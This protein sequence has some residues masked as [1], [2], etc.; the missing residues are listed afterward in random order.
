MLDH[1]SA[2]R[3]GWSYVMRVRLTGLWRHPDFM[4]LWGGATISL[5]GS[6]ITFIALTL[7]AAVSL[8]AT[9]F[10]IG[11]LAA[12]QGAPSLLVGLVAGIWVDRMRRRPI[13]IVTDLGRAVLLASIPIATLVGF[14]RI[15]QLYV[16]MFGVGSL[17]IF[18]AIASNAFLV[19]VVHR[20]QLMEAN[21]KLEVSQSVAL[22]AGPGIG[23][24]LIL[25]LSAPVAI[26]ADVLS[27]LLSALCFIL[28]NVVE[29]VPDV[30]TKR[31]GISRELR[32]GLRVVLGNPLLRTSTVAASIS[33]LFDSL[34][35]AA[36]IIYLTRTL[37]LRPA[38]LG[39]V[40]AAVGPGY[41]VGAVL[42]GRIAQRAGVGRTI[43]LALLL[44]CLTSLIV[45]FISGPPLLVVPLLMA[46]QFLFT[47]AFPLANINQVSLRMAM[48]PD[49]LQG[50]VNAITLFVVWGAAPCGALL[51]GFLGEWLGLRPTLVVGA[52]GWLLAFLWVWFSP[53]RQVRQV[54]SHI[55]QST[56][57]E[58]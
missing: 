1:L 58:S 36:F 45:P 22:I 37:A 2:E 25:L 16:V 46:E 19:S 55:E 57:L 40:F 35:Y 54:P 30:P 23:G 17:N 4:K 14:L 5:F 13:L 20:E 47:V 50:R 53:L 7:V 33:I 12:A 21:G 3:K 41:L 51:G 24:V 38:L 8:K 9:P 42:A 34:A 18:A 32:E 52:A 39:L 31:I 27:Y 11:M 6:Q 48:T 15:E 49:K 56:V 44:S 26:F 10:Q 29:P 43:A 28:I